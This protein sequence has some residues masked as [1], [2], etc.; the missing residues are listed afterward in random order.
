MTT[1]GTDL[2]PV[3]AA[4]S[5]P[6]SAA[7]PTPG[8]TAHLPEPAQD[9]RW[10]LLDRLVVVGFCLGLVVPG[11]LLAVGR[12]SAEIE[13]RPLRQLPAFSVGGLLD[14]A[15]YTQI[16]RALTDNDPVR[17][18]AVRLRGEAYWRL[19]G[20]GN[21]AVVKGRGNWLFSREEIA[22]V[23][24]RSAADI[25]ADLDQIRSEFQAAGQ[26]FRFVLA[27][28]KHAIYP[29]QLDP[30]MPYPPACTDARRPDLSAALDARS[31]WAVNGWAELGRER[32][33]NP[34]GPPLYYLQDS[35][36]TPT[37]ALPAIRALV[38]SF[39]PDLWR[40]AD[41]VS[42]RRRQSVMDLARQVG[43]ARRESV[44]APQIRPSVE[45]TRTEVDLPFKARG[46][47]AVYRFT[48]SGDATLI[49]GRTVIVYESFFGLQ[50]AAIA[51]FFAD[52]TWIHLNDLSSHP[53]IAQLIGRAD[54][55]IFERVERGLYTTKI[56]SLLRPLVSR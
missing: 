1:P 8:L 9:R 7:T 49:P 13:N 26:D 50:M 21:P 14:P 43:L 52:S 11:L 22:P 24:N 37:G 44:P 31:A 16:D 27:P 28:D 15:W 42:G 56:L 25:T 18:T 30:D 36:W 47:R 5:E 20:T 41:V 4:D 45:I 19:G 23:C 12:R 32:T 51:P 29:D 33:A 6:A 10:R 55:V 39:G 46:A 34:D 17:P 38:R 54:R 35:H 48:A 53:E 3:S 2:P 40:D